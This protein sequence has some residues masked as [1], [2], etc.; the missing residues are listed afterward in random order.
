[1]MRNKSCCSNCSGNPKIFCSLYGNEFGLDNLE[2]II[3]KQ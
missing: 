1:M 2:R 3:G